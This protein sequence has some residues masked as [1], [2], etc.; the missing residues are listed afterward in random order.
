MPLI[1]M[2]L[3]GSLAYGM[4][5]VRLLGDR[6][7]RKKLTKEGIVLAFD[8]VVENTKKDPY[9]LYFNVLR[10]NEQRYKTTVS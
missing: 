6:S 7:A 5:T 9:K 3:F 10:G 1:E 8:A 2:N 4:E